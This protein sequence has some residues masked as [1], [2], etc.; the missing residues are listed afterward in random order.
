M[1]RGPKVLQPSIEIARIQEGR[2]V[3][4]ERSSE[5]V[6]RDQTV[7]N[8]ADSLWGVRGGGSAKGL[9]GGTARLSPPGF[10]NSSVISP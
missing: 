1:A 2:H 10:I 4:A 8:G 7:K 5:F 6:L 3:D 9:G